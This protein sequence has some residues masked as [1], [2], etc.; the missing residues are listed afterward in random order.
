MHMHYCTAGRC[1]ILLLRSS[2]P[3]LPWSCRLPTADTQ[4][5]QKDRERVERN[6][7]RHI[8]DVHFT[9]FCISQ[10]IK[11]NG[12]SLLLF[13]LPSSH[14]PLFMS[15]SMAGTGSGRIQC[16]S[17]R[18]NKAH[19]PSFLLVPRS[20]GTVQVP[21]HK[22]IQRLV[23]HVCPSTPR[24]GSCLWFLHFPPTWLVTTWVKSWPK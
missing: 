13:W 12:L 8:E 5:T 4:I 10:S 7:Q 21:D 20:L 15:T 16:W 6:R 18:R 9:T 11:V 1:T 17:R 14:P 19:L 23:R 2:R 3:D 22:A 24:E